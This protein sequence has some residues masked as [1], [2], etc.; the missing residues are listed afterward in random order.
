MPSN[1][2]ASS[3]IEFMRSTNETFQPEMSP[4]K[5]EAPENVESILITDETSQPLRVWLK[6][7]AELNMPDMSW[8]PPSSTAT[9]PD[10]TSR[11]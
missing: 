7:R 3:N 11:R 9:S 5:S 1:E 8:M 6:E 4:S 10:G 2:E